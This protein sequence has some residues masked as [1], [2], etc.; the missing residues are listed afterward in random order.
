MHLWHNEEQ[1]VGLQDG[2]WLGFSM[3]VPRLPLVVNH[4][5]R[6]PYAV[7]PARCIENQTISFFSFLFAVALV[8]LCFECFTA[9]YVLNARDN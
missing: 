2:T 7:W 3:Y 1:H 8:N 6:A 5:D 9:D 4:S